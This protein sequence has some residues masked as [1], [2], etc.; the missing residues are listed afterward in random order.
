MHR[1][2]KYDI[3][4]VRKLT[5]S[6]LVQQR[7]TVTNVATA[8]RHPIRLIA[9]DVR[10]LYNVGSL[11][12]TSDSFLVDTLVLTGFT[13]TPP[14]KE[15]TKT[16]LGATETVP[17][18][19]FSTTAEAIEAQRRDGYTV[20][21]LELTTTAK[22]IDAMSTTEYPVCLVVGNELTGVRPETLAICDGAVMIPMFGV[23]HSLNV[24]VAAGI[25]LYELVRQLP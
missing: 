14:R 17:W 22:Q 7:L 19:S 9:E 25:A 1:Q 24:A 23:K 2:A 21:A 16:A 20:L 4:S 5:H 10:S 3:R 12:R 11:F 8:P 18:T 13:P 15:I 6:E